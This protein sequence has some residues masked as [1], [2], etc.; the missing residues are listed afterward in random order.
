MNILR[1]IKSNKAATMADVIIGMLILIIFTGILTTSFY[2][3]YKHNI[4]IRI[5]A[6]AV[7][8]AIKIFEDIDKMQYEEVENNLNNNLRENYDIKDNYQINLVVQNYNQEDKTKEDII[9]I[10]TLNIKYKSVDE[11]ETYTVKKLKIKEM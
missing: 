7:D 4:S 1:K 3:I 6:I 2:Q 11:S 9:K 8:Y 10:I 5:N